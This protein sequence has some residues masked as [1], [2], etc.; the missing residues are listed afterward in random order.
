MNIRLRRYPVRSFRIQALVR[1]A[2]ASP[3][4]CSDTLKLEASDFRVT[5]G[6]IGSRAIARSALDFR[7]HF[8]IARP[9]ACISLKASWALS[10]LATDAI[11]AWENS[12]MRGL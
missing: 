3:A 11:I 4:A 5:T 6:H 2:M 10:A 12:S 7:L 9:R 8:F 1:I